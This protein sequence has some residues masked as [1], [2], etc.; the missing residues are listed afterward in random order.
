MVTPMLSQLTYEGLL[1]EVSRGSWPILMQCIIVTWH[2][3][4]DHGMM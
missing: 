4:Y 3:S 2:D 1:D